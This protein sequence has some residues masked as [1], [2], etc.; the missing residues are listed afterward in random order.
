MR[1]RNQ[2]YRLQAPEDDKGGEGGTGGDADAGKDAGGDQAAADAAA[3]AAKAA[4]DAAAGS[5]KGDSGKGAGDAAKG[6]EGYWPEDWRTNIAGK[7]EA[8]AKRLS[9]YSSPKDV[10]NALLSVQN[11]IGA[12]ELRSVLP[13]N[14]TEEQVK[15]WREENG[16]PESPDK[17]DLKLADGLVVG[18][19]DKPL[20]DNL[21]KAMHKVNAPAGIASEVVNFYYAQVEA[22]EADRH[23]KDK[24]A[25][26]EASDALH[27]EWGPE[28]RANMN[29]I[30]GLLDTAP[31][32]V[33]DLIKFGRLSDGTPIMGNADAIRWLNNMAREINPVT[34]II[35]N[36]GA[37]ISGA[38]DTEIASIEKVMKE[39]RKAYNED[40]KMQAR[41]RDLYTARERAGKKAA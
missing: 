10:A 19:D 35:P 8:L 23:E 1:V 21:L 41:L 31:A 6:A 13:K 2:W 14:A 39:N 33:K 7:D 36:A 29:M 30:D 26:R 25:A 20:I 9:R 11:K 34:T 12:G 5:D 27:V 40:T 22:N 17:Y 28:F 15:S 18:A 24:S 4:S 16:I 37:N 38:I 32:G 3:A